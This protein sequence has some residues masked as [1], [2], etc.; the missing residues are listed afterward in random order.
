MY[1]A[2]NVRTGKKVAIKVCKLNDSYNEKQF[3]FEVK[4][5]KMMDHKNVT[6]VLGYS[7]PEYY[8]EEDSDDD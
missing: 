8:E 3:L 7:I 4:V 2:V 1:S 6:K 5:Q